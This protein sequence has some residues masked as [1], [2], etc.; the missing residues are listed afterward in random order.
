MTRTFIH[1]RDGYCVTPDGLDNFWPQD[2]REITMTDAAIALFKGGKGGNALPT[3][4]PGT[5]TYEEQ[6]ALEGITHEQF[7]RFVFD[8]S[9]PSVP[10]PD[11]SICAATVMMALL[12]GVYRKGKES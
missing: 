7:V 10:T 8:G 6:V 4:A 3:C 12:M 11:A 9:V 2:D 1:N 5:L